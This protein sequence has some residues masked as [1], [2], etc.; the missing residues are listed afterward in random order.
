MHS[1]TLPVKNA[2]KYYSHFYLPTD[3]ISSLLS[4]REYALY[5][6]VETNTYS[7]RT[8]VGPQNFGRSHYILQRVEFDPHL[9]STFILGHYQRGWIRRAQ[10]HYYRCV[11]LRT[12]VLRATFD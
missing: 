9:Q 12:V 1:K 8:P 2:L 6:F 4:L 7:V 3:E 11:A 10:V 5:V